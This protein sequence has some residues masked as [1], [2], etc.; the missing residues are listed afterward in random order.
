VGEAAGDKTVPL[1][2][3]DL[4]RILIYLKQARNFIDSGRVVA[5]EA[6]DQPLAERVNIPR[7]SRGL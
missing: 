1:T 3:I 6:G 7:Q 5:I 2:K 4:T